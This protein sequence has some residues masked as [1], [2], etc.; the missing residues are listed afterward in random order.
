MI[1]IKINCESKNRVSVL[2][3]ERHELDKGAS[4]V[5]LFRSPNH[6]PASQWI[7]LG[8]DI[9]RYCNYYKND[10]ICL[11]DEGYGKVIISRDWPGNTVL[12]Y[13]MDICKSNKTN[14]LLVSDSLS[15]LIKEIPH[16]ELSLEGISLFFEDRKHLH[17]QTIYKGVK[18]LLPGALI[19]FSLS[20]NKVT[21]VYWY[22]FAD[23]PEAS[24]LSGD[25]AYDYHRF[26]DSSIQRT[27]TK[28]HPVA[29]M[30]SGGTDSTLLLE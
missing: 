22:D 18:I 8:S 30:Y 7:H 20:T 25:A 19:E 1:K 28:K 4:Y 13:W 17:L 14:R 26:L 9:E 12:Y 6:P 11:V 29:L 21:F 27:V 10:S 2:G 16:L 15:E 23:P 24:S 5:V 3:G